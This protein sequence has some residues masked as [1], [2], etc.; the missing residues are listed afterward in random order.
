MDH[1]AD[2]NGGHD[3]EEDIK[4]LNFATDLVGWR[5]HLPLTWMYTS[6]QVYQ[7]LKE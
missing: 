7:A 6:C 2:A 5:R 3:D 1:L 4:D